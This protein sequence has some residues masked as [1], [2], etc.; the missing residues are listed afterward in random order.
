M[1]GGLERGI[2]DVLYCRKNH[3]RFHP[4]ET[5]GERCVL[6]ESSTSG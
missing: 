3:E 5:S 1:V 2:M 6:S 4:E